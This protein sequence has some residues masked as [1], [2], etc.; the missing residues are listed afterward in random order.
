MSNIRYSTGHAP[1]SSIDGVREAMGVPLSGDDT[2][3]VNRQNTGDT[4][5]THLHT[6]DALLEDFYA[7]HNSY[8]PAPLAFFDFFKPKSTLRH[9]DAPPKNSDE[10]DENRRPWFF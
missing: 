1:P 6:G 10:E 7:A 4:T 3:E 9:D 8:E 2:A 5:G